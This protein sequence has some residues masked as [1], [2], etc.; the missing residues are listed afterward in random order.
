MIKC[1]ICGKDYETIGEVTACLQAHEDANKAAA[2]KKEADEMEF[3]QK[4]VI[5]TFEDLKKVVA[6]YN[7]RYGNT[8]SVS[9][10]ANYTKE[11]PTSKV[12]SS[13]KKTCGGL[14]DFL[15]SNLNIKDSKPKKNLTYEELMEMNEDEAKAYLYSL[16][17]NDAIKFLLDGLEKQLSDIFDD[18]IR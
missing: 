11:T 15:K 2:A 10:N 8:F 16:P 17:E 9:F 4:Y 3:A 14:E 18:D 7:E 1:P 6:E 12:T 5:E 13:T